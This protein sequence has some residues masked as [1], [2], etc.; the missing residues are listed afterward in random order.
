MVPDERLRPLHDR[1]LPA[2]LPSGYRART[3]R[4]STARADLSLR[5]YACCLHFEHRSELCSVPSNVRTAD[6]L[7]RYMRRFLWSRATCPK[8]GTC[9]EAFKHVV[10][11]RGARRMAVR[12]HLTNGDTELRDEDDTQYA[13]HHRYF[14]L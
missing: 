12:N 11:S 13:T 3:Q 8:N 6:L 1:A 14:S 7:V 2:I 9:C 4:E 5:V 10:S